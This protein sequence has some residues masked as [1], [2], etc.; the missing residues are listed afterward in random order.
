[1][2]I[3]T[4][5]KNTKGELIVLN[6]REAALAN[7]NQQICNALG[8][9]INITSLTAIAKRVTEQK[10]FEIKPSDY[11]PVLVGNGAWSTN[12]VTYRDFAL[13]GDFE[14]GVINTGT[15]NSRLAEADAGVDSITVPI[16][17]WAKLIGWSIFDLQFAAK[18]GNWDLV[19]SKEKSRKRNW[20]LGI[21][22]I[23]FLGSS[24]NS[25]VKGLLNQT[26][27][28]VNTTLIT[29]YINSMTDAEFQ[30][31]VS[32]IVEAYRSNAARTVYPTHFA[33]PEADYNGLVTPVSTSFAITSKLEYLLQAFKTATMNP[34]FKILPCAY[35]DKTNPYN[36][37]AG[38]TKNI[39]TL[40][41]YE[42]DSLRMDIPVDYT[43]T[44][45]NTINGVQ[46]QNGAYGQF[47]GL[48]S[49][50]PAEILYFQF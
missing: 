13:G 36:V 41:N 31:F 42:E 45:A 20:D 29:K 35:A 30:S 40:Y 7:H 5:I 19:I 17:N 32:A 49:Y 44:L 4:E 22:K 3:E 23:A 1:M 27:P 43:N 14:T 39:Y 15:S 21:Q 18:S 26:A 33:I 6:D 9:E 24:V 28:T 48:Q 37:A 16:N 25:A 38:L 12:I 34:N 8:Y 47:T 11:M 10:F 50:R 2:S 46:Y